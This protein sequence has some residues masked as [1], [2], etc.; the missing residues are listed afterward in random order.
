MSL[1]L[2]YWITAP[3]AV[4]RMLHLNAYLEKS[5]IEARLRHLV[6][7]RVSQING[8]AYCVDLHTHEA[9]RDGENPQRVHCLSVWAETSLFSER[10][11]A[12]LAYAECITRVSETHVPDEAYAEASSKFSEIDLVD[13]TLMISVMNA[14]NRMAISFRR[15]IAERHATSASAVQEQA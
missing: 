15:P 13:L 3:E 14:W 11:R 4:K 9:L 2:K 8:C 12:G 5:S 1:R 7:L 10:E 6:L